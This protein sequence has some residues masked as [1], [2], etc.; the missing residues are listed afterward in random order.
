ML[1]RSFPLVQRDRGQPKQYSY[2]AQEMKRSTHSVKGPFSF[3][4][5]SSRAFHGEN[6]GAV[7]PS[8]D[9]AALEAPGH[10]TLSTGLES[11]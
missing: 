8:R 3:G 2:R 6:P 1:K 9:L 10:G 4:G 7:V 5:E 11:S